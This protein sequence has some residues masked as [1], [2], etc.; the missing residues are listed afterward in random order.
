[1]L[2]SPNGSTIC[3]A[4]AGADVVVAAG[5]LR[6]A[7]AVGAW[8]AQQPGDAVVVAAG[9]RWD[10]DGLRPALADLRGAGAVLRAADT[11]TWER[12]A[13]LLVASYRSTLAVPQR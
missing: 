9:E 12:T 13:D 11:Y 7:A 6:N 8:L 5:C 10:D 3:A 2:P 4:L 1:M